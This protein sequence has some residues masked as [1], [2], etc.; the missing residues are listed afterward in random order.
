MTNNK[1]TFLLDNPEQ[2]IDNFRFTD[3]VSFNF[4][5][6]VDPQD[7]LPRGKGDVHSMVLAYTR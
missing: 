7:A 3:I 1:V 4:S 5:L 2:N 6:T